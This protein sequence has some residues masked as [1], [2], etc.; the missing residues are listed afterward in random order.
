MPRP[1]RRRARAP[2][3]GPIRVV[4]AVPASRVPAWA[5]PIRALRPTVPRRPPPPPSPRPRRGSTRSRHRSRSPTPASADVPQSAGR[6]SDTARLARERRAATSYPVSVSMG[7]V[8]SGRLAFDRAVAGPPP[9]TR[10]HSAGPQTTVS[11]LPRSHGGR[12]V[13][14]TAARPRGCRRQPIAELDGPQ[15]ATQCRKNSL[16]LVRCLQLEALLNGHSFKCLSPRRCNLVP[17]NGLPS[18]W[19]RFLDCRLEHPHRH[20]PIFV[21]LRKIKYL[22]VKNH[23]IK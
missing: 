15:C 21:T 2:G 14:R 8:D 16:E 11:G 3:P 17:G 18:P 4:P 9:R 13:R 5:G 22:Q 20:C 23:H 1:L 7:P 10:F 6:R 12:G 19:L